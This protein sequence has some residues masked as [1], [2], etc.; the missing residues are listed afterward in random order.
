LFAS[1]VGDYWFQIL[2]IIISIIMPVF[3]FTA[4]HLTPEEEK[5]ERDSLTPETRQEV[6]NDMFG[7]EIEDGTE[8][9]DK[10]VA[11]KL[12]ELEQAIEKTPASCKA[13][14]LDAQERAP[15]LVKTEASPLKFLRCEHYNAAVRL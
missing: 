3:S 8:E 4:P 13:D 10:L 12:K 11:I 1:L 9:T 15:H 5:A 6:Q 2:E 7:L 14:Y